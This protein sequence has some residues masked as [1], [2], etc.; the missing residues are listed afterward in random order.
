M[1]EFANEIKIPQDRI[2]VLIGK[3][4]QIK[5]EIEKITK[6]I[7]DVNSDEGDVYI[8]GED[9]LSMF[10]CVE[11]VRAIGRGF[12]P[13]LAF[14]LKKI[15]FVLEVVSISDYAKT[16]NDLI[17]LKGRV[18]GTEGKSRKVIEDLLDINICV[19]GKT[20]SIIG[21]GDNVAIARRAIESLLSG[22]PHSTVYKWLEKQR[23][24]YKR[25]EMKDDGF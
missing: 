13:E 1:A 14:E 24:R 4:G 9:P 3:D 17:R 6:T 5:D 11:I 25:N 19:Y 12:N 21:R 7:L 10:T 16:K 2:A 20:I 22:S 18:I 23:V 15:D 8:K